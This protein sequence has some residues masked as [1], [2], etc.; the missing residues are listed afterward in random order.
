V[1]PLGDDTT[2][3]GYFEGVIGGDPA[4]RWSQFEVAVPEGLRTASPEDL[5]AAFSGSPG[6][7]D[8]RGPDRDGDGES[9]GGLIVAIA[10][11]VGVGAAILLVRW[12][13]RQGLPGLR[14]RATARARA[15]A[16]AARAARKWFRSRA[17]RMLEPGQVVWVPNPD[18]VESAVSRGKEVPPGMDLPLPP[19]IEPLPLDHPEEASTHI[20]AVVKTETRV[21]WD[22]E[23]PGFAVLPTGAQILVAEHQLSLLPEQFHPS[24]QLATPIEF[25][26]SGGVTRLDAGD[27]VQVLTTA[28]DQTKVRVKSGPEVWVPRDSIEWTQV[29]AE[30]EFT[31]PPPSPPPAS[32]P[33]P[34]DS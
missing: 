22:P 26:H 29:T 9:L 32:P 19:G 12:L 33:P 10:L 30:A 13:L 18:A 28:G 5:A 27:G 4:A 7:A 8:D 6:P 25:E 21:V 3:T 15:S 16:N 2:T 14:W 17:N 24:H 1:L 34:P 11:L 23:T 20:R 31:A